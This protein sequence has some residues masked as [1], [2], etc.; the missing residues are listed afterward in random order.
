MTCVPQLFK[1]VAV[2]LPFGFVIAGVEPYPHGHDLQAFAVG[3]A[4]FIAVAALL[5]TP[6]FKRIWLAYGLATV[7]C[8]VV[9]F[10]WFW[11][12]AMPH[13]WWY[14]P[15]PP[16]VQQFFFVDGEASYDAMV[17]NLFLVL[18]LVASV[19]FAVLHLTLAHRSR[20]C[21]GRSASLS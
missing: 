3:S 4:F 21:A 10:S 14:P 15:Q 19:A 5:K 9:P 17:S 18:W 20:G 7:V 12:G 13:G 16:L 8:Y 2:A 1:T 11:W 6:T